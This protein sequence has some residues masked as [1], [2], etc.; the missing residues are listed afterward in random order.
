MRTARATIGVLLAVAVL[1]L[2]SRAAAQPR[3]TLGVITEIKLAR[4]TAEVRIAGD[5]WKPAAPLQALRAGDQ[6]RVTQ[7]ASVV[8]LLSGGRGIAR[9]DARSSPFVLA[10]PAADEGKLGKA[11][12]LLAESLGFLASGVGKAPRAVLSTRSAARPPE[13]VTPRGGPVLPGDLA[14]EW[15]GSQFSRYTVRVLGPSDVVFERKG[16]TG[17][18]LPYPPDAPALVPGTT[19]R[20]QVVALNQ[21]PQE[22]TFEVV[23]DARVAAVS[24]DLRE[25]E[26]ALG[27]GAPPSSVAVA[28]AGYLAGNGL[29]HDARRVVLAALARDPDEPVLHALL[30]ALYARNGLSQQSAEA[31]GQAQSLLEHATK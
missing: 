19:Y 23:D 26:S 21:P 27:R 10:A 17:A 7:G 12:S 16:V 15:L 28:R 29:T 11:R 2:A 13:I 1:A 20:L 24:A 30:G 25:L 3:E 22:T 31:Y 9:V 6:V 18:R 5:E 8:V 14:F 4:G